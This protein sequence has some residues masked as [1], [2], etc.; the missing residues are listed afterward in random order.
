[1]ENIRLISR[2]AA[3]LSPVEKDKKTFLFWTDFFMEAIESTSGE[4]VST[5]FPVLIQEINKHH[6]PSYLTV[7][8]DDVILSHVMENSQKKEPPP[9]T[10]RWEFKAANIKAVSASKRDDRSMY[11]YVHDS[12][13]FN[14]M[15][16]SSLHCNKV[17]EMVL[18]MEGGCERKILQGCEAE[19]IWI[20]N[21][22]STIMAKK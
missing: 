4:V 11:M 9:G 18:S 3:T 22:S 1:M 21:T 6:T 13:D 10:H 19:T 20:S 2:C 7:N 16:P 12:D 14:L 17:I 5:R 8:R 15:F